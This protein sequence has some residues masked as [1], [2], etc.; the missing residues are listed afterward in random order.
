MGKNE[1]LISVLPGPSNTQ[2]ERTENHLTRVN[3]LRILIDWLGFTFNAEE[4]SVLNVLEVFQH[5]LGI[6]Q[7]VWNV[8]RKNYEGYADSFTFENINIY[9]NG[10][11][12]QGIHVDI[13]GQ[14]CRFL[15]II[16]AKL[17]VQENGWFQFIKNLYVHEKVKFTRVDLA[18]DDF[19]GYFTLDQLLD[20][21]YK[22]EAK[23]K[24]KS[25][26]PDGRFNFDGENKTGL[27]IYYGSEDSRLQCLMYEKGKQLKLDYFWNRTEL[28]FKKQRAEDIV[29]QIILRCDPDKER[30]ED[31]GL[32]FAS[33][34][35]DYLTFLE[36][37]ETDTNKR[38]W[39][40]SFFWETFLAGVEPKKFASQLPDRDIGKIHMWWERQVSKSLAMLTLAYHD[41]NEDFLKELY[42]LG[43]KKMKPEDFRIIEDY[44]RWTKYRNSSLYKQL[45]TDIFTQKEKE[46]SAEDSSD[47]EI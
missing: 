31:I 13:T 46:S 9:Y 33:T 1:S 30:T 20:K 7:N 27:S 6:P 23:S 26:H 36:P 29:T 16:F 2:A 24:F 41:N 39:K 11:E 4:C 17:R 10:L 19:Y 43:L 3:D 47:K 22:G 18:C 38:R 28:R 40:T 32:I 35:K 21:L 15:E 37:S 12:S 14:G 34:L 25:W 42:Q 5:Y 45:E 8:G 44:R